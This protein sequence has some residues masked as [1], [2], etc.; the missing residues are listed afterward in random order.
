MITLERPPLT[1]ERK[2]W[3][4]WFNKVYLILSTLQVPV[5]TD[6]TRDS[7]GSAGKVIFNVDDGNMNFD[8]GNQWILPD[9]SA[10]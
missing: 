3:A 9:G 5:R 8:D 1:E 10:T 7:P 2:E 6:A 4:D